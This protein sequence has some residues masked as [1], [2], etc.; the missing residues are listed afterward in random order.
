MAYSVKVERIMISLLFSFGFEKPK[1]AFLLTLALLLTLDLFD[2]IMLIKKLFI[3][4]KRHFFFAK[5]A[6]PRQGGLL[7]QC[8]SISR[9]HIVTYCPFLS[10]FL[11][12]FKVGNFRMPFLL[13]IKYN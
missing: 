11:V 8:G 4:S 9:G 5:V 10:I 7:C 3:N 1:K 13:H 6:E 2:L 12:L